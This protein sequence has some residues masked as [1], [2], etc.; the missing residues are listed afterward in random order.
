MADKN[1]IDT[2]ETLTSKARSQGA[3]KA[4]AFAI[5]AR[6]QQ[7][8]LENN[9]VKSVKSSPV[10]GMGLRVIK[11]KSLGFASVNNLNEASFGE[12]CEKA[13]ELARA[14]LTDKFLIIPEPAAITPLKGLFDR[15]LENLPLKETIGLAKLM[16]R[17]AKDYDKRV[18]IDSG[19]VSV[20]AG[21]KAVYNS[22]GVGAVERSTTIY[23]MIFGMARDRKEVSCFD[24]QTDGSRR[25]AG[26]EFEKT[27]KR[28][29]ENVVRSLGAK[30]A[31]SFKGQV[32][33]SPYAA[34]D[35][36]LYPLISAVNA[37]NV[38]KGM[39]ALAGKIGERIA[40]GK[41][42][43]YDDGILRDGLATSAFDREGQPHKKLKIVDKGRLK[44]YLHNSYTAARDGVKTTG[45][46]SGSYRSTP[47]I[48]PTNIVIS[49]GQ[50]TKSELIKSVKEGLLVTRFSGNTNPVSGVFS[51]TVKGGFYIRNGRI[52]HPVTNTMIAGNVFDA[53]TN[54]KGIS[55]KLVKVESSLLPYITTGGISITSG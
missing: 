5:K 1:L 7:V 24:Y 45:N 54:I 34:G 51:G 12:L 26:V 20:S 11:G 36:F 21:E 17:A 19:T 31:R 33:L 27:G 13:L 2:L 28:L 29:A 52:V 48:S 18:T 46:A 55:K 16:L 40:S 3:D 35:V 32:I 15:R 43:I 4:E 37:Q 23:A 9:R 50:A 39:S 10:L 38:Q 41:L 25:L 53:I 47:S 49:P 8:W 14:N 30:P 22:L 44:T 42:S 6:S